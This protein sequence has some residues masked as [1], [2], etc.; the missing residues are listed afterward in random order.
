MLV[1]LER[2]SVC[3]E[4]LTK[5]LVLLLE[6]W[7]RLRR[8]KL[9]TNALG[10]PVSVAHLLLLPLQRERGLQ[11][12]VLWLQVRLLMER[13]GKLGRRRQVL[14]AVDGAWHIV[15][16]VWLLLLLLLSDPHW[17][18]VALAAVAALVTVVAAR[19]LRVE[20]WPWPVKSRIAGRRRRG[21]N[22]LD[23]GKED[24]EK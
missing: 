6:T 23:A 15:R 19:R 9:H 3:L 10:M 2:L 21:H 13:L 20:P 22:R 16:A 14:P 18:P 5:T 8:R 7:V 17:L 11:L 24:D 4:R 12:L 1:R